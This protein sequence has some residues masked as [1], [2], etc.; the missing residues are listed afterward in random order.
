MKSHYDLV[1]IGGGMVGASLVCALLPVA[2]QLSLKI[3]LIEQQAM[4]TQEGQPFQPSYDARSTALAYGVRSFYQATGLW[5]RL[6]QHLTPIKHIHV[7]DKGR[8][9]I[10]RLHAQEEGVE[11]LGYV[12]ENHWLGQVLIDH[13]KQDNRGHVDLICPA[14]VETVTPSSEGA[15]LEVTHDEQHHTLNAELVVLADGGR[16]GL[17]QALGIHFDEQPYHQHALV[18]NV[19]LDRPH[20][21]IAYER[22]TERG[23]MALLPG[24]TLNNEVRCGLVWTLPDEQTDHLLSLNERDFLAELHQAF[25]YRAGRFMR[26]GERYHY[27]L[28]LTQAE[29]Q[30]RHGL[31]VLGNAAHSLHPIAGQGYNLALRGVTDLAETII[32]SRQQGLR[33][34]DLSRLQAYER[35]RR[36]DQQ[37]TIM[38]SDRTMR[39]FS[40]ANPLLGLGR[41]IGLQVMDLSPVAKTLFARS[42]MGLDSPALHLPK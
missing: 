21:H 17:R 20:Q 4:P 3:A 2:Q 26:V 42:A 10:T 33:L 6:Q 11:A 25:G 9:G 22:F 40:N 29:E 8:F 28:K 27:P 31:V 5:D 30:V 41:S 39:L 13:I 24:E 34:G 23:P 12:V 37:R 19:S 15:I 32:E 1:I 35:L 16:S 7:S 38:F 14:S 36:S 18:T